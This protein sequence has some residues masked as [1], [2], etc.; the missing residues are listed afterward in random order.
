MSGRAFVG[1]CGSRRL[2]VGARSFVGAVVRAVV[3]RGFGVATGCARGADSFAAQGAVGHAPLVVFSAFGPQGG[4]FS[5]SAVDLVR[6]LA[7]DPR[8]VV[9]WWAGGDQS[10]PLGRRLKERSLSWLRFLCEQ[11]DLGARVGVVAFV[12]GGWAASPGSW[13]SVRAAIRCGLPVVVFPCAFVGGQL[14]WG[15]QACPASRLP[16]LVRWVGGGRWVPA[17]SGVWSFGFRWVP[18]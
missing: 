6:S 11:A 15:E 17:G 4:G 1:F 3:A 8:A 13:W 18:A 2:P 10:V 16:C 9:H 14:V 5:G 7:S 12:S